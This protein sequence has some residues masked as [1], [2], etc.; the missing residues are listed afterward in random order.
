M[1]ALSLIALITQP[2]NFPVLRVVLTKCTTNIN[3]NMTAL[4]FSFPAHYQRLEQ[5]PVQRS[6]CY[7]WKCFS[8]YSAIPYLANFIVNVEDALLL[9]ERVMDFSVPTVFLAFFSMLIIFG[10]SSCCC[11]CSSRN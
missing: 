1:G 10:T 9:G 11:L 7:F 4:N 5:P 2:L 8:V 6:E 3:A